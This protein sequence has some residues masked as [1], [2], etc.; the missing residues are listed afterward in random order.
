MELLRAHK[1]GDL[2]RWRRALAALPNPP[3]EPGADSQ[4]D[5]EAW[6]T[7][8]GP[9]I[10]AG[11]PTALPPAARQMLREALLELAP[12]RK[13]PFDLH[14]VHINAEWRSERK[15][16]RL[17]PHVD[18][19]GRRV[20]DVG[21]GNGYYGWRMLAAGAAGVTGIDPNPLCALQHA[22][23]CH[24]L[25]AALRSKNVV[26]PLR[27]ED[28]ASAAAA[29]ERFD[30]VFSMGVIYHRRDPAAH[31]QALAARAR[32]G[33]LLVLESLIA[34][35]EPLRPRH[36]YAGMNNVHLVP[37]APLLRDWVRAAGFAGAELVDVSATTPDEQRATEW[38][39]FHSLAN[40][41]DPADTTRTVEGHPAPRR[42]VVIARK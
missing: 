42:A 30:A 10:T 7:A 23:V 1:H 34:E 14:G 28:L 35:G 15:W 18:L 2:P 37:T 41:L 31:A 26:L 3:A 40:A 6:R 25:P 33:A 36:R 39:P 13:G 11:S 8:F 24:F 19:A 4:F 21:C 38:M 29:T 32:E 17:A 12:W 5:S 27:M 16:A 20:L 9:T 22:A